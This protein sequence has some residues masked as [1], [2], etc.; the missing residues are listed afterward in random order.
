M[1]PIVSLFDRHANPSA[2]E[3]ME[4][5]MKHRF[6]FYGLSAP[7]R[8][9]LQKP[10]LMKEALP[11]IEVLEDQV[12]D[13]WS[14]DFRELHYF[15]IELV[16]KYQRQFRSQ[17]LALLEH[18]ARRQQWWDSI[19]PIAVRLMGAYFKRF[20]EERSA[21]VRRWLAGD[22]FW[23]QRCGILFQLKYKAETDTELLAQAILPVRQSNE[24]FIQ[25]AIGWALREYRKTDPTWVD[26][27]V[28]TTDFKPL[29][30]REAWKHRV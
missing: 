7:K 26:A 1:H 17:D 22:D 25:K 2:A 23:L 4:A 12:M 8:R 30:R 24:F 27:L 11:P 28:E 13:L 19:D 6:S 10:Y 14:A 9:E 21:A 3:G 16:D 18:M 5:Y 29:S 20:P 15:A